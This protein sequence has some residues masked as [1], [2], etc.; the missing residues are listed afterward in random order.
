MAFPGVV[1]EPRKYWHNAV[2]PVSKGIKHG[3]AGGDC[4][5][6]GDLTPGVYLLRK[7]EC[8]VGLVEI[9]CELQM[10]PR[11]RPLAYQ[12]ETVRCS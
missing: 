6:T 12:T 8:D 1:A 10:L 11:Q 9:G 5:V 2:L 7:R 3:S 4:N